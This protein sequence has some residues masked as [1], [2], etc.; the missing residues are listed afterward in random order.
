MITIYEVYSTTDGSKVAT[1]LTEASADSHLEMVNETTIRVEKRATVI[2]SFKSKVTFSER[3]IGKATGTHT[4]AAARGGKVRSS[5]AKDIKR[6]LTITNLEW[7]DG[8][9]T[10][11]AKVSGYTLSLEYVPT[12]WGGWTVTGSTKL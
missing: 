11:A 1:H 4:S 6:N 3:F 8:K 9:L 5:H 2:N 7:S 10:G 12:M